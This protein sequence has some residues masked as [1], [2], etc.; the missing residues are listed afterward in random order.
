MEPEIWMRK[1]DNHWEYIAV[2]VDDIAIASK[3]PNVISQY[4]ENTCKFKLKGSGPITFHLGCDYYRDE[5]DTLCY[6][7]R[8]Y[9][10]R[11]VSTYERLFGERPSR[12]FSSPL[13][14]GDHPEIDTSDLLDEEG[15]Q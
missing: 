8:K 6:A 2:Y 12:K 4:L 10:D 9:I 3:D 5:H 11:M 7:P 14:K 13:E 15:K 1:K